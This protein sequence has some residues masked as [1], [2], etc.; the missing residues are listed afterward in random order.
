MGCTTSCR[1][2]GVTAPLD[3]VISVVLGGAI[4]LAAR[5]QLRVS[6]RSWYASRYFVVVATFQGFLVLPAAAYRYFF[7]P[8]WAYMY[9]FEASRATAVF[10]M[11]G[12]SA[13]LIAGIVSFSLGAYCARSQREWLI[14][15]VMGLAIALAVLATALGK[16]R[17]VMVGS[18]DQW[19]GSFGLRPMFE[20]DLL[21]ALLVMGGCV[22]VGWITILAI[23][24]REGA[25]FIRNSG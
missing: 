22:V 14:L 2:S 9:L 3:I 4:A 6:S 21:P 11:V 7:H 16:A 17:L 25:S 24:T 15:T 23:L 18:F 8:D 1:G 13:V 5:G 12:L 20:T 10:G 19:H